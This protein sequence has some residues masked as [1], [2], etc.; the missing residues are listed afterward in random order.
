MAVLLY[1]S[2]RAAFILHI[3]ILVKLESQMLAL[4]RYIRLNTTVTVAVMR[5]HQQWQCFYYSLPKSLREELLACMMAR[6]TTAQRATI[7]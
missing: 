5:R 3:K 7:R 1:D 4:A 6:L 2:D